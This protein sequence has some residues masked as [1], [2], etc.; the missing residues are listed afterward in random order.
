MLKQKKS[1]NHSKFYSVQ[2]SA[3][4]AHTRL[5]QTPVPGDR[6]RIDYV[7]LVVVR[8]RLGSLR[9]PGDVLVIR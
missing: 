3:L 6:A 2:R 1:R 5:L 8:A 4:S 7:R 9:L